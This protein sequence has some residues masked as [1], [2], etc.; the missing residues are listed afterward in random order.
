MIA[1]P[2]LQAVKTAGR[3]NMVADSWENSPCTWTRTPMLNIPSV[4]LARMRGWGRDHNVIVSNLVPSTPPPEQ[5]RLPSRPT[6]WLPI[7]TLTLR[8]PS[9]SAIHNSTAVH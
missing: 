5:P 3:D 2:K 6:S 7:P 1:L 4:H 9:L 8:N